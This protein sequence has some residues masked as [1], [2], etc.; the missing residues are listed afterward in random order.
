MRVRLGAMTLAAVLAACAEPAGNDTAAPEPV[1]TYCD[2]PGAA[3]NID[4]AAEPCAKLSS[5]RIFKGAAIDHVPNDGVVAYDLNT[6]LF[7]DYAEKRRFIYVPAGKSA[8]YDAEKAFDFPVGTVITKTF[9]FP[10]DLRAPGKNVNVIETRLLMR[11][12][13]G[14]VGLPY[15]WNKGQTDAE[16]V[17]PGKDLE[18]SLTAT[19][20]TQKT[21]TY[22][23]PNSN[24]C[25]KCHQDLDGMAPIGPKARSLNK[26]H[27]YD[28]KLINQLDHLADL[29]M[30]SGAPASADAPKLAVWN[31]PDTGTLE[32]RA[33][34]YLDVNCSHCHSPRGPARTSGLFL[35]SLVTNPAEYG[36]CKPP[37][38]AAQ[39]TG[40]FQYSIV[41][42]SPATSIIVY[43]LSSTEAGKM[44]PELGRALVHNE[45]VALVREWIASM[46]ATACTAP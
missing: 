17:K 3:V 5:Y 22:H 24:E 34:A 11:R 45:G 44:M 1:A 38:A 27:A 23:V 9:A 33:R 12:P 39:G 41:P 37:V 19:D 28:G 46:P 4:V 35:S 42:G 6:P 40:G 16:L 30:L 32:E 8:K 13:E 18:I 26:A 25:K 7:S 14:W 21:F 43:R 2:E 10:K 29:G 15:I 20:G 36:V 31:D